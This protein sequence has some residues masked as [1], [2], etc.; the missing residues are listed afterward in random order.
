MKGLLQILMML[1]ILL[2]LI[3]MIIL[4]IMIAVMLLSLTMMRGAQSPH[5]AKIERDKFLSCVIIGCWW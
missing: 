3:A 4:I 5:D 1:I 2:L